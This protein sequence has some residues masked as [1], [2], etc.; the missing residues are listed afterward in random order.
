MEII[1]ASKD[2]GQANPFPLKMPHRSS[3]YWFMI[4][5]IPQAFI[6]AISK[7][8]RLWNIFD[9]VI[10]YF[11]NCLNNTFYRLF[12]AFLSIKIFLQVDK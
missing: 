10:H 4:G 2:I 12:Q 8:N 7:F 11:C 5:V 9:S 3:A 1:A 6:A